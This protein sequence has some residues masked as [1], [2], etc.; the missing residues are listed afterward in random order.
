MT[1][2]SSQLYSKGDG[3]FEYPAWVKPLCRDI[4]DPLSVGT[5]NSGPLNIV[6]LANVNSC[7]FIA[8]DDLARCSSKT[9]IEIMGRVDI[10][11]VRG[12]N[13]MMI[14]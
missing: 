12:C 10:S 14:Q 9:S 6:D 2:M 1:E 13:L 7:A 8:T 11:D 4:N 5:V 3:I